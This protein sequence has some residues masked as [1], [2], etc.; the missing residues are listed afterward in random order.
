MDPFVKNKIYGSFLFD[1]KIL[2]HKHI[3]NGCIDSVWVMW[4]SLWRVYTPTR[5]KI[6]S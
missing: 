3:P 5:G 4:F 2:P 1:G 6:L